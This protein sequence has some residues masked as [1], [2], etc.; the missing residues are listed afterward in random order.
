MP[1]TA[2]GRTTPASGWPGRW[3]TITSE[4]YHATIAVSGGLDALSV[5]A[6]STHPHGRNYVVTAWGLPGAACPLVQSETEGCDE[7]VRPWECRGQH[8]FSRFI[9]D[10]EL[11]DE[12]A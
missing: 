4:D 11:E 5:H 6:G 10:P 9:Y 7:S 3:E 2:P 12:D 1:D 8:T